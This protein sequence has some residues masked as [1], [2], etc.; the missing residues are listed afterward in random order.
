MDCLR[1]NVAKTLG[2]QSWH[3][4]NKRNRES[5]VTKVLGNLMKKTPMKF[6]LKA[7]KLALLL[8]DDAFWL[9]QQ[10]NIVAHSGDQKGVAEAIRT[11]HPRQARH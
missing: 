1:D 9:R 10:G 6:N 5:R 8:A 3:D 11:I 2:E 4:I 7:E